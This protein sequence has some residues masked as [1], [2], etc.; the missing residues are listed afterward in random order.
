MKNCRLYGASIVKCPLKI[1]AR[2]EF[3]HWGIDT[4]LSC[5]HDPEALLTL[6]EQMTRMWHILILQFKHKNVYIIYSHSEDK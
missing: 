2:E 1:E 5:F 4:V 3:D 6:D